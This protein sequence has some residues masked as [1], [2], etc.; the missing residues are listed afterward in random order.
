MESDRVPLAVRQG[1]EDPPERNRVV[2][3]EA[4]LWLPP[5]D[6]RGGGEPAALQALKTV[7]LFDG[8]TRPQLRKLLRVLHERVYE[9]DEIIF[10]EGRLGAGMYVIRAGGVR[11][12]LTL[13]SGEER[14]VAELGPG[15]FFGEMALLEE[16]PRSATCVANERTELLGFFQPD[17][18][19]LI[20]RDSRLG[21][22]VLWNLARLLASRVRIMNASLKAERARGPE[23]PG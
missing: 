5:M 11:I 6:A 17:L 7:P 3:T 4:A 9:R 10:R 16:A 23:P 1:D 12:V 13:P 21:S 22:R 18:D 8:L 15:H 20:E 14:L 2:E 19:G